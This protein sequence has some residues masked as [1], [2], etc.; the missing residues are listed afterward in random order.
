MRISR[1]QVML[2]LAL[3]LFSACKKGQNLAGYLKPGPVAQEDVLGTWKIKA[4]RIGFAIGNPDTNWKETG[5]SA[6]ITFAA[7]GIFSYNAAYDYANQQY[8]RYTG[9]TAAAGQ[10]LLQATVTPS[11]NF[12]IY[13]ASAKLINKNAL[14]ITYMGVD[15]TPQELYI[16]N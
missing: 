8:D 5:G 6:L 11:G 7:S 3:L 4:S 15:Y 13:H 10:F 9:D 16:R 2:A 1:V 14:E 12:P